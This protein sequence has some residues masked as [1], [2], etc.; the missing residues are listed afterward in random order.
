M[1]HGSSYTQ[2]DNHHHHQ[3]GDGHLSIR[4]KQGTWSF[5]TVEFDLRDFGLV[6]RSLLLIVVLVV[7][8][9]MDTLNWLPSDGI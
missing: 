6:L 1:C 7:G 9:Y 2:H 8:V 4:P 5:F 3:P